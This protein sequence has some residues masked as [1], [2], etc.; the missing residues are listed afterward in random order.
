[1]RFREFKLIKEFAPPAVHSDL[2]DRLAKILQD[3]PADSSEHQEAIALLQFIVNTNPTPAAQPTEEPPIAEDFAPIE[4][5]LVKQ[6]KSKQPALSALTK[7]QL[8]AK[9]KQLEQEVARA[10]EQGYQQ[11]RHAEHQAAKQSEEE[12]KGYARLLSDKIAG[13]LES[14]KQ[15]YD[16]QLADGDINAPKREVVD[17]NKIKTELIDLIT[18]IFNKPILGADTPEARDQIS[19]RMSNFMKRCYKGIISFDN[20]IKTGK[21]N[22]FA[23]LTPSDRTVIDMIDNALLKAMPSKTAGAWGPGELGLCILGNP[24]HKAGKGDLTIGNSQKIELKASQNPKAGGRFGTTALA[25]GLAGQHTYEEAL[26]K[27]LLSVGYKFSDK[28]LIPPKKDQTTGAKIAS[29]SQ[30][31]LGNYQNAKGKTMQISHLNF[32]SKFV[33]LALNPKLEDSA[34]PVDTEQF[35]TTVATSCLNKKYSK[36][37]NTKWVKACV[38][39][40]GTINYQKF[41]QGYS[42]MLYHIYQAVDGVTSIM[43]LNPLSGNYYILNGPKDLAS[44]SSIDPSGKFAHVQFSDTCI[45]FSDTQGKASPQIGI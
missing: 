28:D 17:K 33:N 3:T 7:K 10:S 6:A 43:V 30:K 16:E 23:S 42:M 8:E 31:Y 25:N 9:I 24:V 2:V 37:Y 18:N 12:I 26:K 39:S 44:A 21:G 45:N 41:V 20:L 27:L 15:A 36:F 5:N 32:G 19:N 1:M 14:I 11:G 38:L 34:N 40:N 35:L 13:S 4:T 22:I 29:P